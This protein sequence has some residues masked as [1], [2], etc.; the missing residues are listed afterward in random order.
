MMQE[1][2]GEADDSGFW[3]AEAGDE[4]QDDELPYIFAEDALDRIAMALGGQQVLQSAFQK[5]TA[6][7]GS[8]EWKPKYAATSAL[9]TLAQA[10]MEQWKGDIDGI[11]Q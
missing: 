2:K 11:M 10:C 9:G 3:S 1:I 7:L 8:K 4:D 6:M 5:I